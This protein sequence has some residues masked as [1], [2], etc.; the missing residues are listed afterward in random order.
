MVTKS[1]LGREAIRVEQELLK[2]AVGCQDQLWAAFGGL[3]HI[4]FSPVGDFEVSPIIL[5]RDR[6]N[7]LMRS[8]MLFFTG[9]SRNASDIAQ[10]QIANMPYRTPQLRG[11]QTMV[12]DALR[13]LQ[14]DANLIRSLGE[15]LHESW[16]LK[17][18]L[19]ES[20]STPTV[21]DI[22]EAARQAGAIGG[23]LLGAGGGGF[24]IFLVEPDRRQQVR[25]RL[26]DLIHVPVDIDHDGSKIVLY[27]PDGL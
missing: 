26:A 17:R 7:E 8:M 11:I 25:E 10:H 20:V 16:F 12:G 13:I 3:N 18:E 22:Y 14:E 4:T 19:A 24:M 15:L 23:K 2:E 6:R 21:D 9:F 27:Q 5:A 1:E